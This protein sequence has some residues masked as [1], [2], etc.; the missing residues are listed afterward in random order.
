MVFLL[1]R[2]KNIGAKIKDAVGIEGN[3]WEYLRPMIGYNVAC[4]TTGGVTNPISMY[5]QQF[6]NFVEG[7][8]TGMS[9]AISTIGGVVDAITDLA[10]GF[11]TDRTKSRF[12]KHRIWI[13]AGLPVLL[14]GY[15]MKWYSFGISGTGNST[16]LFIYYLLASLIYSSGYTM[17]NIPHQAMLPTVAPK[18]F[19]RTQYKIVEYIFNMFGMFPSFIFMSVVLGGTNMVNPSPA[20]RPKYLLCG[21]IFV[22]YFCWAPLVT[23][24][25]TKE[26]S[27]LDLENPPIDYKYFISEYIQVFKNKAFRDYFLINLFYGFSKSFY[28][29]ADQF[30]IRSIADKYSHFSMLNTVGGAAEVAGG[31]VNYFLVRYIDKRFCGILLAPLMIAGLL[32][33]GFVT[34]STPVAFLYIAAVLYNFGFSGPGFVINNIQPDVTDVDELITG[35]RREGVI[36][37]FYSFVKKTINSFVTGILGFFLQFI[38]Y[39]TTNLSSI[40][41]AALSNTTK[42]GIRLIVSYL[43]AVFAIISLILI[44]RFKMKKRDHEMIQSVIAAKHE[45][46]SCEISESDKKRLEQIAGHKWEDMWIGQADVAKKLEELADI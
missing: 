12:G 31:P 25:S 21:A 9:G 39:D 27:S 38:G 7:M 44:F 42:F 16:A 33:G 32:I 46:G 2:S 43:P 11:I 22:I 29:Y 20:D 1:S 26:K 19:Q 8:S 34:P 15:F 10:M 5:H 14:I 24:F 37:T 28:N 40:E 13:I 23:F 18:Y 45:T 3:T 30:Y 17:I 35:R 36:G 4:I 6:L 41:Y